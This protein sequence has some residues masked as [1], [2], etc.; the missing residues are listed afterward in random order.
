MALHRMNKSAARLMSAL[1]RKLPRQ[2]WVES[3]HYVRDKK[4]RRWKE[5]PPL[6]HLKPSEGFS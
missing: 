6:Y 1:G 2:L 4:R 5:A 3:C